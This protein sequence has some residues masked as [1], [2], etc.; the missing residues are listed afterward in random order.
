MKIPA[1]LKPYLS[2]T[3]YVWYG[4]TITFTA[5]LTNNA[6][7]AYSSLSTQE[8]T[9]TFN[10][11]ADMTMIQSRQTLQ[12][13]AS[14]GLAVTLTSNTPAVCS[15]VSGQVN[16]V[17]SGTCSITASQSG[18]SLTYNAATPITRS[19]TISKVNQSVSVGGVP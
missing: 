16:Q 4:P 11:T 13:T 10:Q 15:I 7:V 8:Q 18:E 5:V 14:S 1:N 2:N 3:E 12:A 9:I 6:G 17:A 19:F